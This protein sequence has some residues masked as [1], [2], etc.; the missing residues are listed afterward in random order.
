MEFTV[1]WSRFTPFLV[2]LLSFFLGIFIGRIDRKIARDKAEQKPPEVVEKFI[3]ENSLISIVLDEQMRPV[4]KLDGNPV[5]SLDADQ[6]QRMIGLINIMRPLL[7]GRPAP[8]QSQPGLAS[9]SAGAS[10]LQARLQQA[11]SS[12]VP[13]PAPAPE[14]K[15]V[16]AAISFG[17]TGKKIA[18]EPTPPATIAGQIDEILQRKLIGHPLGERGIKVADSPGGGVT[19]FIGTEKFEGVGDVP[20]PDVKAILQQAIADWEKKY[21]PGM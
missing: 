4:I 8:A 21:T 19:I 16:P 5:T 18:Q 13:I 12:Q 7:E 3:P 10:P 1:D 20:Y 17:A 9:P 15:P 14:V 6:R 11:A 2:G